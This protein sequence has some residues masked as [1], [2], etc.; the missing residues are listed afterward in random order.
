ME[1]IN[2]KDRLPENNGYVLVFNRL[3]M[4]VALYDAGWDFPWWD[5]N[6]DNISPSHWIPLPEPPK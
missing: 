5:L 3:S 2:T 6:D 4:E 1:W